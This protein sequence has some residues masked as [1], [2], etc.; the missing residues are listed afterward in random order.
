MAEVNIGDI[1]VGEIN[2]GAYGKVGFEE[3]KSSSNIHVTSR[4]PTFPSEYAYREGN[5]SMVAIVGF[6]MATL[7]SSFIDLFAHRASQETIWLYLMTFGGG[8]QLYAGAKDF[9]HGNTLTAC[10]FFLFGAHWVAKGFLLGDLLFLQNTGPTAGLQPYDAVLGCYYIS[11][12]LFELMLT[13]CTYLNPH[14][15]WLLVAILSVVQLKLILNTIHCWTPH[16]E[17]QQT[18]GFLGILVCLLAFYSFFAE[19]L[20]EHGSIIPTGKFN[21]VKSRVEVKKEMVEKA[22]KKNR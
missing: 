22:E 5:A 11:F 8:L 16:H 4:Q 21:E 19:S 17:L 20:A 14:G 1:E 13:V 6:V 10:I 15:S 2:N 18:S 7:T 3:G 9:H 12:T